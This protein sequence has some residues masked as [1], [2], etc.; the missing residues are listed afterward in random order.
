[1]KNKPRDINR[2]I[3]EKMLGYCDTIEEL[4][5]RF[6]RSFDLYVTDMAFQLSCNMCIIQL[7]ELTTRL[8]DD[9]KTRHPEVPWNLIKAM[10]NIHTHD[11]ERV[12][13]KLMWHTLTA[14]IPEL[15]KELSA[16]IKELKEQSAP[17]KL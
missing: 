11:Y 1:M 9:F 8:P 10:R 2:L 4:V 12:D 7:G 5:E 6:N 3:L 14:E 17:E 13:F 15:K 16:I